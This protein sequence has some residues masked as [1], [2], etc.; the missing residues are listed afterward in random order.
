MNLI[1]GRSIILPINVS[2]HHGRYFESSNYK[3]GIKFKEQKIE[4]NGGVKFNLT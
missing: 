1:I 2:S 4:V 3:K